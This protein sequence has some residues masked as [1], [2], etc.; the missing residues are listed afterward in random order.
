MKLIINKKQ[1][2]QSWGLAE[3]STSSSSSMNILSS[4][5]IK[6]SFDEV[7]LQ[8]TDIRTS[9]ICSA[10]GVTVVEQGEAVF[11]I[12]MV[13]D[14]FKKA[15]GEEFTLSVIDGKVVLKA[16]RSKYNFSTYPVSEFPVLP[17]SGSAKLF[18]KI[19]AKE[20]TEVLE[21]GTLAASTGEEFPLYLSS[22]NF[23]ISNGI[24]N[25]ISTDTRRLALS[26]AVVLES[27]DGVSSLLPMKGVKEVQR[28]LGSLNPNSIVDILYDDAQFYFKAENVEFTVRRVESRFPPYEKIL[29]KSNTTSITIDRG[30]LISAL[31]RVD[32]IVR[33]YNRMVILDIITGESLVM[34]AK[35]P[36]FGQA[37]EEINADIT[38]ETLRMAVNS[39]FFMEALKVMRDSDVRLTFNG[40]SGHMA[41][42]HTDS[43]KFLCLIAPINLSEEEMKIEKTGI[44]DGDGF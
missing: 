33:D 24:L 31:E 37:V 15:P 32:V 36:D 9:I 23:Q 25:I 12:K 1:F 21:E 30:D 8:A 4:V 38:G 44:T 17:S 22:A 42:R 20:L 3:R 27:T 28:I 39:K 35:A 29:P 16:G 2:L 14:L 40:P 11:P 26:G 43:D 7:S 34:R 13:S 19:S 41:V 6:A 5:L 10:S 18:C